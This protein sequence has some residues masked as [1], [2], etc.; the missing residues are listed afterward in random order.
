[1]DD[2]IR[3]FV[4][5]A[6]AEL[7]E[8]LS[9]SDAVMNRSAEPDGLA[10]QATRE[11]SRQA[12][13]QFY[14]LA[15]K[16][17]TAS[18]Y[19]AGYRVERT[20]TV[21]FLVAQGY[22]EVTSPYL[23]RDGDKQGVRP[24]REV[25]GIHGGR[26]S[27]LVLRRMTDFGMDRSFA[28]AASAMV[29]HHGIEVSRTSIR[30]R[31][32][33][34]AEEIEAW[35][36]ARLADTPGA[37]DNTAAEVIV[38]ADGC[39]VPVVKWSSAGYLGRTQ[40]PP[41]KMLPV[42]EWIEAR[43]A[44]ARA[45]G[46]VEPQFVCRVGDYDSL[47]ERM[48]GLVNRVGGN[49]ATHVIGVG[50]GGNGLME[51]LLRRFPELDYILDQGHLKSHLYGAAE[52]LGFNESMDARQWVH[53]TLDTL[54]L[55]DTDKVLALLRPPAEAESKQN[56]GTNKKTRSPTSSTISHGSPTA[57]PTINTAVT[58]GRSVPERSRA[59]IDT[60]PRSA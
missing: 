6:S 35:L 10:E 22:I 48:E 49:L 46:T 4:D 9:D 15:G 31:T 40:Y 54:A 19:D 5:R 45:Q 41:D 20:P 30:L 28:R 17:L 53:M 27:P 56:A 1:V 11:L 32:L 42:M 47:T 12:V 23:R 21:R 44:L 7:A 13:E 37:I 59:L 24:L 8:L 52:V 50:D 2:R 14:N 25:Y 43:T 39:M 16:R 51:A 3:E 18:F 34:V 55:G 36:D 26:C 29:E 38:Q 57:S 60:S 33:A 58:V